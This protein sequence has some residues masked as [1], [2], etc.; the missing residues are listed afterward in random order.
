MR[1]APAAGRSRRARLQRWGC[2]LLAACG[3]LTAGGLLLSRAS[4]PGRAA[5]AAS[6]LFSEASAHAF[7]GR[8]H[9][10]EAFEAA[11]SR[12]ASAAGLP[13]ASGAGLSLRQPSATKKGEAAEAAALLRALEHVAPVGVE[14]GVPDTQLL[15][16]GAR[17]PPLSEPFATGRAR[18]GDF[19][20]S[21]VF[22]TCE[23]VAAYL[24][25]GV[26][27][28]S[29]GGE[30]SPRCSP[31][32]AGHGGVHRLAASCIAAKDGGS[33]SSRPPRYLLYAP[34][35]RY[36]PGW[37]NRVRGLVSAYALALLTRRRLLVADPDLSAAFLAPVY[38]GSSMEVEE[39]KEE[40]SWMQWAS[41]VD[42]A[43][44]GPAAAAIVN[45]SGWAPEEAGPGHL[46]D[47]TVYILPRV[48]EPA[49]A[50]VLAGLNYAPLAPGVPYD[51][52]QVYVALSGRPPPPLVVYREGEGALHFLGRHPVLGPR[53]RR[54]FCTRS[55]PAVHGLALPALLARPRPALLEAVGATMTRLG[56]PAEAVLRRYA[57]SGQGAA[58]SGL[59]SCSDPRGASAPPLSAFE[60]ARDAGCRWGGGGAAA[61]EQQSS[62]SPAP[63]VALQVRTF[64]LDGRPRNATRYAGIVACANGLLRSAAAASSSSSP[65]P[66]LPVFVTSDDSAVMTPAL[67]A[68]LKAPS[69]AGVQRGGGAAGSAAPAAL[70]LLPVA[71]SPEAGAEA[72]TT[73]D[74]TWLRGKAGTS[75]SGGTSEEGLSSAAAA[76]KPALVDWFLLGEAATLVSGSVVPLWSTFAA[77]AR[78]RLGPG[79]GGGVYHWFRLEDACPDLLGSA[80]P[81]GASRGSSN[82]NS[83]GSSNNAAA[84]V[85]AGGGSPPAAAAEGERPAYVAKDASPA[86]VWG[87]YVTASDVSKPFLPAYGR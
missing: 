58:G 20:P 51:D 69:V 62:S 8:E 77:T 22:T 76:I 84:G 43:A 85:G 53:L 7:A 5:G 52:D 45:A 23:Q 38:G 4:P 19:T 73:L 78:P 66:P 42:A 54:A 79:S 65:V 68:A 35:K 75:S 33:S 12:L 9:F 49:T 2:W 50:A 87:P 15:E 40:G 13:L 56:L 59:S 67:L 17:P 18:E 32:R 10:Y 47:P 26:G 55:G 16:D 27:D 28:V 3:A 83:N 48:K 80:A 36:G 29:G 81:R 24:Y 57:G 1:H 6:P 30:P 39:E 64:V 44:L 37:G 70:Q 11:L 63:F 61:S 82:T 34:L 72:H 25:D 86:L 74:G 46:T 41:A 31:Y 60:A 14:F 21:L 71:R